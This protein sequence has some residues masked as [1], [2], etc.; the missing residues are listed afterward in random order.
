MT[1]REIFRFEFDYQI[2]RVWV[3]VFI[4]VVGAFAFLVTRNGFLAE[5][6]REDFFLNSPFAIAKATVVSSEIWLVVAAAVAGEAAAR[7]VRAGMHP[8]TYTAPVRKADYLGG[9]F[10]AGFA[11]NALILLAAQFGILF[12]VHLP[13]VAGAAIGP[14]R[15]TAYLAAYAFI[16]VPN[17][18]FATA[19]QFSLASFSRRA[20]ASY[21][22][23]VLLFLLTYVGGFYL[24]VHLGRR[25]LAE[26]LDPIGA[27]I[28]L[29]NFSLS[30]TPIE[31]STRAI[32]LE[33]ALL[34]NRLLWLAIALGTLAATRLHFRVAHPVARRRWWRRR[35]QRREKHTAIP[36]RM[37]V[38]RTSSFSVPGVQRTFGLVTRVCQSLAIVWESFRSLALSW[39]GLVVL[40]TIP[41][42]AALV[43]LGEMELNGVLLVPETARVVWTLT[44][45]LTALQTPWVIIPLLL[46]FYAGELVWRERDAGMSGITDALPVSAWV[47]FLGK[48]LGLGLVILVWITLMTAGGVLAQLSRGYHNLDLGL[49]L[50]TLLGLQAPEYVL[51]ALLALVMHVLVD[52]KYVGHLVAIMAYVFIVTAYLL[53]IEHSLLVYGAGPGWSYTEMRGYGPSLGS[54]LWFKLY[55]AGWALLLAVAAR[56]LWVRGR[57]T[58]IGRRLQL[59]S[60]RLSPSTVWIGVAAASL[61]LLLGGFI[62]YNTN[63][64]NEYLTA[65]EIT[66]LR[67]EYERR[68]GQFE[69]VPQPRITGTRLRVEIRPA[70]GEVE[71]GGTYHLVN[72]SAVPIDSVHLATASRIETGPISFNRPTVR[73]FAD[74]YLGH[75]IH[76]LAEPLQP[77]DSLRLDFAVHVAPRG[78]LNRGVDASVVANGT[79]FTN[80]DWLPT[81]GYQ[82]T[83]ELSSPRDRRAHGLP[84]RP[85][86][87]S[88]DAAEPRAAHA[89]RIS[90]EAIVGTH[91]DQIAV[92]PGALRRTWTEGG[93]RYFH[94]AS[95]AP[96]GDEYAFFSARYALHEEVWSGSADVSGQPV[97]IQVYHH[98][99]HTRNLNRMLR[100]VRASL[101]YYTAH[102]GRY[103]Y[104]QLRLVER[105]GHGTGMHAEAGILSYQEGFSL[106]DPEEGAGGLHFPF[107]VVAHE[108]A[109]QWWGTQFPPAQVQG[110]PLLTES[111][112]W[113]SAMQVIRQTYGREQ[114]RRLLRFMRRPYPYPPIRRG[115]PLLRAVD[116]YAGYR[117]GPFALYALSEYMGEAR[118]NT[119]M[120]RLLQAHRSG[121]PPRPTSLDLYRELAAVT[122]DS[123]HSLLHDL[124]AANTFWDFEMEHATAEQTEDGAW[125][126]TLNVRTSKVVADTAGVEN[127]VPIDEWVEIGVFAADEEGHDELSRPLYVRKHRIH[128]RKQTV[129]VTVPKRPV[130]AG[131]D[132][133]HLLDWKEGAD[134]DNIERLEIEN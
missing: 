116:P 103:L 118:V 45:P 26:L 59:A 2:R 49:Y 62:F 68:L 108:V 86:F 67:A 90:F 13:G 78:F 40:I 50:Q 77:G 80:R 34:W 121:A 109:H 69:T 54:W 48:L 42:L 95:D 30:W 61:V 110:A 132:P 114:L 123:L 32:A 126:A 65:D 87:P 3:W 21:A 71:I 79:Y 96:I 101:N 120:R 27:Q 7:D 119:A 4:A 31:K 53:G 10:I 60:R 129:T 55:W 93:R 12:A 1:F 29:G 36:A 94:Y 22:G 130:L 125:E 56:L 20:M 18:F 76:A 70:H 73:V 16:G 6:L 88:L 99:E 28:V 37:T 11:L 57:E 115:E 105:P 104:R 106:W 112:A 17:A 58:A 98:P 24:I 72:D 43:V 52:Q 134:D 35:D 127:E 51:F 63:V 39:T 102:F 131:I 14:F 128:K 122:P 81:V 15:P 84:P 89:E 82:R 5:A 74:E 41:I 97:T 124:F 92:A 25:E 83:R 64:R 38:A 66:E 133:H 47:T 113:Y 91:P 23:S 46:I 8:L 9:R 19:I 117:R 107:A 44:A 100:G 85:L 75:R 111:L 33:G